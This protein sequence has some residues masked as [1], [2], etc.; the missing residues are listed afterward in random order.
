MSFQWL[1][2]TFDD[3]CF[4]PPFANKEFIF[5]RFCKSM[6]NMRSYNKIKCLRGHT[7][8]YVEDIVHYTCLG[9]DFIPSQGQQCERNSIDLEQDSFVLHRFTRSELEYVDLVHRG[10]PLSDGKIKNNRL[11]PKKEAKKY[12]EIPQ[13]ELHKYH[14]SLHLFLTEGDFEDLVISERNALDGVSK[15][16]S[17][18]IEYIIENLNDYLKVFNNTFVLEVLLNRISNKKLTNKEVYLVRDAA[19]FFKNNNLKAA[20]NL[21]DIAIK[22]KPNGPV[23][24]KIHNEIHSIP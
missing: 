19:V 16:E 13:D 20:K 7:P 4:M 21:I 15:L 24:K 6:I 22:S 9:I 17:T 1:N 14:D 3:E 12:I 11:V 2:Q 5:N 18:N 10:R 23:I 8:S